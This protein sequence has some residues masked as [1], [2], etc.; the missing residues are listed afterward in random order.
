MRR[1]VFGAD[2]VGDVL[3]P[4]LGGL[5]GFMAARAGGNFLAQRDIISS[6]PRVGKTIAAAAGVPLV[7]LLRKQPAIARNSGAIVLGLGLAASEAW[8]RDMPLLG[9][10]PAAAALTEDLPTETI[11]EAMT[12]EEIVNG[13][14]N[15][16]PAPSEDGDGLSSY[17]QVAPQ[18]AAG[19]GA[20]DYYTAQLLGGD[21]PADQG[22]VEGSLN[23]MEAVSTIT[24]TGVARVGKRWPWGRRVTETFVN[25]GNRGHAGGVFARNLFSG[26]VG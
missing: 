10:S 17:F 4:L 1:N 3:M 23:R 15:G 24:P 13:N 16:E 26:M 8:L 7:F 18:A 9:G 21:D 2:L 25:R 14:G 6:D 20:E 19:L 11:L 22:A 5:A 12:A